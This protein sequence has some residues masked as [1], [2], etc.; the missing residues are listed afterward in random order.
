MTVQISP[1]KEFRPDAVYMHPF[2][3]ICLFIVA[4]ATPITIF[5]GAPMRAF[6]IGVSVVGTVFSFARK[7]ERKGAKWPILIF[8]I[9]SFVAAILSLIPEHIEDAIRNHEIGSPVV[10]EDQELSHESAP[11]WN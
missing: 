7:D 6:I 8:V 10:I 4:I 3:K 1:R 9:A 5:V 11:R 2:V